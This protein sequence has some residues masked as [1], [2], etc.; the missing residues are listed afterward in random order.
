MTISQALTQAATQLKHIEDGPLMARLLMAHV[1]RVPITYIFGFANSR[2]SDKEYATFEQLIVRAIKNEPLAYLVGHKEFYGLDFMVTPAVLIPRPETEQ[3]VELALQKLK[4]RTLQGESLRIVDVG[5]GSGCVAI[6]IAKQLS[7]S[8]VYAVDVSLEALEVAKTNADRRHCTNI[9]FL[10]GS[11]L[12]P[13]Q[14]LVGAKSVDLIVANL[15]YVSDSEFGQLPP[16]VRDF[17]PELALKSGA[18][19]DG[20]N[21]QLIEQANRWLRSGG[22]L[23]YETTNG[24]II[25]SV[26][27]G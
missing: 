4:A 7:E 5:T 6:S 13:L 10:H 27:A 25:T 1:L 12:E 16:N 18:Q 3:L 14:G 26:V 15:P 17:E 19:A 11:L 23:A 24:K 21:L 9:T 20:L 8:Y 2:L 22:L